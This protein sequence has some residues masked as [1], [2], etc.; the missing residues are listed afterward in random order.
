[1]SG[2]RSLP[3]ISSMFLFFYT[4]VR[5]QVISRCFLIGRSWLSSEQG[6]LATTS[7]GFFCFLLCFWN[8]QTFIKVFDFLDL[9]IFSYGVN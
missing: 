9:G 5:A 4:L 2:I 1:M 6:F 8:V 3:V 7:G